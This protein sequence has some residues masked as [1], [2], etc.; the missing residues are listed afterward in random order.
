MEACRLCLPFVSISYRFGQDTC[1]IHPRRICLDFPPHPS[2]VEV[3]EEADSLAVTFS[4]P[5]D[6]RNR[7]ASLD[8]VNQNDESRQI[9]TREP[10]PLRQALTD[11]IVFSL[12]F[13]SR[14]LTVI[15]QTTS[16]PGCL[17][18]CISCFLLK[19]SSVYI[20][21]SLQN[22]KDQLEV[23]GPFQLI[24]APSSH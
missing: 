14:V 6:S 18:K 20:L 23:T 5:L 17:I 21:R 24:L 19:P 22:S 7:R 8:I 1:F 4:A 16:S 10:V 9:F 3:R 15:A 12:P 13:R 2:R 11:L